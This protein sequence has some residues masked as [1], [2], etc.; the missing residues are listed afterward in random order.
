VG[1]WGQAAGEMRPPHLP[2]CPGGRTGLTISVDGIE[3]G[4]ARDRD[5]RGHPLPAWQGCRVVGSDE[6]FVMN[7]Q[8]ENS[9]DGHYFG[10]IPA[11]AII[12]QAFPVRTGEQ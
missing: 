8:S 2:P 10:A 9:L 3:M 6:V 4:Q 12:G 7:W 1:G 11:S 5:A